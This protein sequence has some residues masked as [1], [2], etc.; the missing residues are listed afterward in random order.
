MNEQLTSQHIVAL[1]AAKTGREKEEIERFI[2]E[3]VAV[4]NEG[5]VKDQTV[6]VKGLGV[7]K[8]KLTKERKSSDA[9]TGEALTVPP[10]HKLAFLPEEKVASLVNKP[11]A[12][13]ITTE[14]DV[15]YD[16][17]A[18][19][20]HGSEEEDEAEDLENEEIKTIKKAEVMEEKRYSMPPV[21]ASVLD[22][23]AVNEAASEYELHAEERP[24]ETVDR[25]TSDGQTQWYDRPLA[26]SGE[27]TQLAGTPREDPADGQTQWHDRLP[28]DSGEETQ[29]LNT[30][31][32]DPADE[33]TQWHD[34]PSADSGDETQL[35][36][37]PRVDPADGQ[38][39]RYGRP[40]ADSGEET[41]MLNTFREDPADEQTQWH[42]RLPADSGEETQLP[43][44]P[45]E[46]PA[47]KPT[48]QYDRPTAD[49]GE[50]TQLPEK[51]RDEATFVTKKPPVNPTYIA[52]A[53]VLL[54]VLGGG[55][56]YIVASSGLFHRDTSGWISGDSFA[57]PGDSAALEEAQSKARVTLEGSETG[58]ESADSA[59]MATDS[60]SGQTPAPAEAPAKAEP[61][62]AGKA[63][64]ASGRKTGKPSTAAAST[65]SPSSD[66]VLARVTMQPGDRLTLLALK[67]Y[68]DKIFWVHIYDFNKAKIGRNPDIVP[69]GM[70]I[71]VPSKDVYGINAND[72]DSREKA[73]LI[74]VRLKGNPAR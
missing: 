50:A 29:L 33:Q 62:T 13:F 48:R 27:E 21:P 34:R 18:M 73:R 2:E 12:S 71:L 35:L 67:Y 10:R 43:D 74:Q 66:K 30:P 51:P 16:R 72:A 14:L 61:R 70:E 23:T 41:Q 64:P 26:D 7:F 47:D 55:V 40:P 25:G 53:I 4:V 20:M 37:T 45:R 44:T 8:V 69:V 32:E 49:S 46:D 68:G 17:E 63:K 28:A 22:K 42:D 5:I 60:L 11:F 56:W 36:N 54:I 6:K 58:L 39:Q 59:A 9:G 57:L 31:R 24:S 38:R 65:S 1:L 15:A 3:W 19:D 52:I